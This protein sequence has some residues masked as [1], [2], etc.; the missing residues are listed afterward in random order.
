MDLPLWQIYIQ[1]QTYNILVI[2]SGVWNVVGKQHLR[3]TSGIN[4][5]SK[6]D[7]TSSIMGLLSTQKIISYDFLTMT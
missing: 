3:P 1:G 2:L 6:M 5:S 7:L 4:P